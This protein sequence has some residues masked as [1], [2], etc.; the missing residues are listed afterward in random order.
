MRRETRNARLL[1]ILFILMMV[2]IMVGSFVYIYTLE[3]NAVEESVREN[4]RSSA[5]IIASQVDGDAFASIRPGDENTPVF[6]GLRDSLHR[7]KVADPTFR[8]IYTMRRNGS[9]VEFVVDGDYG[10]AADAASIGEQY[11]NVTPGMLQGFSTPSADLQFTTDQWGTV[12]S[13]YAPI[14]DSGGRFVGL[15]GVDEDRQTVLEEME[16]MKTANFALIIITVMLFAIGAIIFDV[17][18]TRVEAMTELANAKLNQLNSIIRH[19]IFN[20]LTG[21]IGFLEMAQASTNPEEKAEML[22]TAAGLAGR[23]QQQVAFTRDYQDLGL[24]MPR[25]QNVQEIVSKVVSQMGISSVTFDLDLSGLEVYADPLLDRVFFHLLDNSV[26]HGG[27]VTRVHGYY[28]QSGPGVTIFIEDNGTGI[29]KDQKDAIFN[30]KAY[31]DTGLGLFLSRDILALTGITIS[32]TGNFG[33][34]AR[35]EIH[36]PKRMARVTPPQDM[37]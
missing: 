1:T 13:G 36:V 31:R 5:T 3:R 23:I 28:Q 25:W 16:R 4:L 12:L 37:V 10:I 30:R 11:P 20:T 27:G 7:I 29:P 9:S 14:R 22:K 32:E 35:F 18:R 15:V 2:V 26:T 17:R 8:Y 33:K 6:T 34:G 24:I 19:D 21:L